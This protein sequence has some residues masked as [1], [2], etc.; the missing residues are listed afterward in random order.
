[1]IRDV[2]RILCESGL[3]YAIAI[4]VLVAGWTTMVWMGW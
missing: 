1:M 3:I 2:W 4:C